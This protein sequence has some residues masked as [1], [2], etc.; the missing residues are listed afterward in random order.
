MG[1]ISFRL[2]DIGEG[3]AAAEVTAWHVKIGEMVEEDSPSSTS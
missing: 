3:I 1:R 2:P